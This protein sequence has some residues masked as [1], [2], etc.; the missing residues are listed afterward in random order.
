MNKITQ[1]NQKTINRKL[2]TKTAIFYLLQPVFIILVWASLSIFK[3]IF[4]MI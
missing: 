1:L 2:N 3:L 4:G